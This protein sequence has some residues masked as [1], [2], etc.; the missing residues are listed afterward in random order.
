MC[1]SL[2]WQDMVSSVGAWLGARPGRVPS[3]WGPWRAAT[4]AHQYTN[5]APHHFTTTTT[6]TLHS[7]HT[8]TKFTAT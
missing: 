5:T 6:T 4:R 1:K 8:L 7:G 2:R 3:A